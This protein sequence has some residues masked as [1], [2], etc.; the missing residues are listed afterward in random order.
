MKKYLSILFAALVCSC[1][2]G[3][4][5]DDPNNK[6]DPDPQPPVQ[7]SEYLK[8]MSFNM[9]NQQASDTDKLAW[10]YRKFAVKEM[11]NEVQPDI[12][13]LQ[14]CASTSRSWYKNTFKDTYGFR[15]VPA[16]LSTSGSGGNACIMYRLD[17]FDLIEAGGYFLSFTPDEPSHC[18][19]VGDNS[20][21]T[22]AWLHLKEKASGKELYAMSTHLPVRT[23]SN[24]DNAPYIE[25]R[26]LGAQLNVTRMKAMAGD[27]A[28]CFIGGDMNCSYQ[29][30][31]GGSNASGVQVLS[32]YTKW[33]EDGRTP[34]TKEADFQNI[35]PTG[36]YSFNSFGSGTPS[37]SRNLD[38]IFFRNVKAAKFE[39]ITKI[40]ADMPYISDHYPVML[41]VKF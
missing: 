31:S 7:N 11:I 41:T 2:G 5:P 3:D 18:F 30:S 36:V 9:R 37:P 24:Y 12:I 25:A 21:R 26:T 8:M 15:D 38:H 1:G 16:T 6:K 20:W 10:D 35:T 33:M 29:T 13:A 22:S 27:D 19:N 14:E 39:T 32:E 28:I 34:K 40:Y 17:R 23:N 4:E